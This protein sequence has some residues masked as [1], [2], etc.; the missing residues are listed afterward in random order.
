MNAVRDKIDGYHY[1]KAVSVEAFSSEKKCSSVTFSDR[2][3]LCG[4]GE[5]ILNDDENDILTDIK[6]YENNYRVLTF[7]MIQEHLFVMFYWEINFV[8]MQKKP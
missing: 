5:F 3:I 2:K 1:E 6:K 8:K 4:A 7:V